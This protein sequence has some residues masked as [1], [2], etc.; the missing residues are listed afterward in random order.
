MTRARIH[1]DTI[2]TRQAPGLTNPFIIN[3]LRISQTADRRSRAPN[4]DKRAHT[5]AHI[6]AH[7]RARA[8]AKSQTADRRSPPHPH[9]RARESESHSS[10][11]ILIRT[12]DL[13]KTQS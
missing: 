13:Q 4:K 10:I 6:R 3:E 11:Y 7:I 5:R 1:I 2:D 8:R 12:N 9:P